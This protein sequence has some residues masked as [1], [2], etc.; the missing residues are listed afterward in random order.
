MAETFAE[1]RRIHEFRKSIRR[2]IQN[3]DN[4]GF[5][6]LMNNKYLK[7]YDDVELAAKDIVN[8]TFNTNRGNMLTLFLDHYDN[9]GE[10]FLHYLKQGRNNEDYVMLAISLLYRLIDK[11]SDDLN[12]VYT[13]FGYEIYNDKDLKKRCEDLFRLIELHEKTLRL[14]NGVHALLDENA[15]GVIKYFVENA[16]RNIYD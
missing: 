2:A 15:F 4:L 10:L 1:K 12:E 14:T 7:I 9:I 11:A 16:C 8:N 5:A 3:Y 13:A 6:L